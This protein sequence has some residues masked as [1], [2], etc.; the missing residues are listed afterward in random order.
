MIVYYL[1]EAKF[2]DVFTETSSANHETI[3]PDE[4]VSI[5]AV[6]AHSRVLSILPWVSEVDIWHPFL[7]IIH[8]FVLIVNIVPLFFVYIQQSKQ[9]SIH[10]LL[11]YGK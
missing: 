3:F 7:L 8:T 4:A 10:T 11:V 6:T 9:C 1:F 2:L 5:S